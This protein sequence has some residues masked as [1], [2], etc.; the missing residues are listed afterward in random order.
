MMAHC[1]QMLQTKGRKLQA[2]AM[3]IARVRC[4]PRSRSFLFFPAPAASKR[5]RSK[6]G[7]LAQT[8]HQVTSSAS[9]RLVLP[10]NAHSQ[11]DIQP[12]M[13]MARGLRLCRNWTAWRPSAGTLL[14][15]ARPCPPQ[16]APLLLQ[17]P[18]RGGASTACASAYNNAEV[19]D[20][21]F[22]FRSFEQEV[23]GGG[24]L[25]VLW[26]AC[27]RS[28]A[29]TLVACSL[30]PHHALPPPSA[31]CRAR[32]P[33]Y[34]TPTSSTAAGR[35]RRQWRSGE[36]QPRCLRSRAFTMRPHACA[37]AGHQAPV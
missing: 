26:A 25:L 7:P 5:S 9:G 21:A 35:C 34:W 15:T 4:R 17:L 11:P 29:G 28:G 13:L 14:S 24:T 30:P 33:L 22:S 37:R 3:T 19:Y 16:T 36:G 31:P 6:G 8:C 27:K 32:Q 2:L 12:G 18:K 20:I 10:H 23:G 1:C